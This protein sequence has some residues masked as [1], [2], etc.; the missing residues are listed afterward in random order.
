MMA[1]E[2]QKKKSMIRIISAIAGAICIIVCGF[3][4]NA[5]D[6]TVKAQSFAEKSGYIGDNYAY[7]TACLL[8]TSKITDLNDLRTAKGL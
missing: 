1:E 5:F 2:S 7:D 6:R 8:D 3:W 4:L